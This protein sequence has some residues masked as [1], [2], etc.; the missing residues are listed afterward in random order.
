MQEPKH[1][2]KTVDV[3]TSCKQKAKIN[4]HSELYKNGYLKLTKGQ[5]SILIELLRFTT[6]DLNCIVLSGDTKQA[7]LEASGYSNGGLK[8]ALIALKLAKLIEPT[9]KKA[10]YIINPLFATK[11]NDEV[12]WKHYQK[13]ESER[14]IINS[15]TKVPIWEVFENARVIIR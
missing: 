4:S 11:G 7:I 13:I 3:N 9:L 15:K 14:R 10:E 8:N 5:Q 2:G 6:D 12:V 1:Y